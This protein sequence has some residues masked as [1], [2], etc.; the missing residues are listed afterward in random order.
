MSNE[1]NHNARVLDQ[2][3]KQAASYAA[4]VNS[5][6]DATL[7]ILLEALRPLPSDRLLDVGCG[8][9]RFAVTLAPLVANVVGIDLTDGMLKQAR[10][11]HADTNLLNIEWRQ[12]DVAKL[13]FAD[14]EFT[15]VTTRAMLHHVIEPARVIAEMNRVCAQGGRIVAIDL[16][17]QREKIAAFDAVEILR[18]PSHAHV[19]TTAELRAMGKELGLIEI[20]VHVYAARMPLEPILQTSYP[21]AG[22]LDRVRK[23]FRIDA[24][25]GVDALGFSARIENGEITVAYPM[26]MVV[27][28]KSCGREP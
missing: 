16:T 18:D 20:A 9:G 28:G 6:K 27:W 1:F 26:S 19:L 5:S 12:G 7:P 25:S 17:P 2:F 15:I 23:L 3:T 10:Q 14:G 4:L 11:L 24:E 22:A 13:P 21:A 8:T